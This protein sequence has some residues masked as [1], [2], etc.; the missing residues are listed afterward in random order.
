MSKYQ[1]VFKRVEKKYMLNEIQYEQIV[2]A[3]K[4]FMQID[5]YGL[6]TISNIYYDTNDYELIRTS[7]NK[8]IY[9]EK[10][11]LR[12]YGLSTQESQ[13][14]LEIKKKFDGVVYKRRIALTLKE[15]NDYL[16]KGKQPNKQC[17]ITR[18]IDWFLKSY[19]LHPKAY[20]AYDRIA[21]FGKEDSNLRITFDTNIRCRD[22][23]LDLTKGTYGQQ[24][25]K[26]GYV[27]MEIKIPGVMP[28]WLAK[29]LDELRIY[30]TSF[31]K[32]GTYYQ[33]HLINSFDKYINEKVNE[34][35]NKNSNEDIIGGIICA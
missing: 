34:E 33:E 25:L 14:F 28:M 4:E 15:A 31:S 18:E 8:P 24:I 13:V 9:K 35:N 23:E 12:S 7:L 19:Q 2:K 17:Q 5:E 29:I 10:L 20:V 11:R 26:P 32:Y 22:S 1:D 3:L 27:L 6:H 16:L 30:S 21:L